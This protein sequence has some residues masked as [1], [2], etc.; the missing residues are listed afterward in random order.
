MV[1]TYIR[2]SGSAFPGKYVNPSAHANFVKHTLVAAR[3]AAQFQTVR[4]S[5]LRGRPSNLLKAIWEI[6]QA[7]WRET[8]NGDTL[9]IFS[10]KT[11]IDS[12]PSLFDQESL[13][14]ED[15]LQRDWTVFDLLGQALDEIHRSPDRETMLDYGMLK[16]VQSFADSLSHGL[17]SAVFDY[18]YD[19]K[20]AHAALINTMLVEKA[21]KAL[22]RTP[23]PRRIRVSGVL[24]LLRMSN[25]F[26]QM[27]LDDGTR[28]RGIWM[29]D[30]INLRTL[31]G[32]RVTMEGEASFRANGEIIA[33]RAD[34][35]R[36]AANADIVYSHKP[37]ITS[38]EARRKLSQ[39]GGGALRSIVG[40]WPGEESDQ[41]IFEYLTAIS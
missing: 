34:A 30:T 5:R 37:V 22:S 20:L 11:L 25:C 38:I 35:A 2:L 21:G 3:D 18:H 28:V 8:D 4:S 36:L 19:S 40:K 17:D 33:L 7:P 31:L 23:S 12:A 13:F 15:R 16:S 6:K 39:P 32:E 29:H 14:P 1:E 26:F 10:S 27:N 9:L 41:E 24:D